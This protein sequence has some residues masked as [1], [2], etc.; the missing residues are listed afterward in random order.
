[1]LL[2]LNLKSPLNFAVVQLYLAG[3]PILPNISVTQQ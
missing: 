1:M 3:I 2:G